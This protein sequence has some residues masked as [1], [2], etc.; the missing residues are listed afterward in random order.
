MSSPKQGNSTGKVSQFETWEPSR[1]RLVKGTSGEEKGHRAT[2]TTGISTWE[3]RGKK[4][5]GK[6][7]WPLTKRLRGFHSCPSLPPYSLPDPWFTI[8]SCVLLPFRFISCMLAILCLSC[9]RGLPTLPRKISSQQPPRPRNPRELSP[10][11]PRF[12]GLALSLHIPSFDSGN[13][14]PYP[15]PLNFKWGKLPLAVCC[16]Q[17]PP[18]CCPQF[19]S[20]W[21]QSTPSR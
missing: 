6:R 20:Q 19:C 10:D 18:L 16:D 7:S 17:A 9:F 11:L 1:Q 4:G 5:Q 12:P 8:H 13:P 15:A 2:E 14:H 3:V 21:L